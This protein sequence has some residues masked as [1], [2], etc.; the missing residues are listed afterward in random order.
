MNLA[1]ISEYLN[2]NISELKTHSKNHIRGIN[3]FKN[4]YQLQTNMKVNKWKNYVTQL[5]NKHRINDVKGKGKAIPVTGH[6]GP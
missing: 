6:G 3:K 1:D 2:N 5:L 4:S